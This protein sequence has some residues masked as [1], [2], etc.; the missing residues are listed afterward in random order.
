MRLFIDQHGNRFTVEKAVQ[1]L[2]T[3]YGIPGRVSKMYIDKKDG[4]TVHTG[5]VIGEHWLS[6][7]APVERVVK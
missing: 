4:S 1:E 3:K 6:E 5:Y 2:K 7:Y